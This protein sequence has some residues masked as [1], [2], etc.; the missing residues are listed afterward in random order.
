MRTYDE[1]CSCC[2]KVNK[3]LYLDET[4]GCFEC[5]RCGAVNLVKMRV[6]RDGRGSWMSFTEEGDRRM[7][8]SIN[9]GAGRVR[10]R[11]A[12]GRGQGLWHVQ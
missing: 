1:V 10:I 8:K 12:A 4:G 3:D 2:G 5:D 9:P 7:L 6:D 11:R